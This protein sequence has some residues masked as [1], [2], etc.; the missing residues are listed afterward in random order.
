[1]L[2]PANLPATLPASVVAGSIGCAESQGPP[3][4]VGKFVFAGN[5]GYYLFESGALLELR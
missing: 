5:V 3:N 4:T 1:M 2:L